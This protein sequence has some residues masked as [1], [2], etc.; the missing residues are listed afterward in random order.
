MS[1]KQIK[2]KDGPIDSFVGWA[3]VLLALASGLAFLGWIWCLPFSLQLLAG[4]KLLNTFIFFYPFVYLPSSI[5]CCWVIIPRRALYITALLL[6][7]PVA[8]V[9]VYW[10][11]DIGNVLPG[12]M[13]CFVFITLWAL[14]CVARRYDDNHTAT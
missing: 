4:L 7:L 1:I 9:S 10:I 2:T 6:N 13:V 3:K 14:L 12:S 8:T 5:Y 11:K